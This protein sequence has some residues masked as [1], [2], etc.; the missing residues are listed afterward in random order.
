MIEAKQLS[1]DILLH[2]SQTLDIPLGSLIATISLLDE[3]GTVPF[4]AR[5][6]KEATGALDEV[7]IRDFEEK[8]SYFRELLSRRETILASISEQGKLTDD[9]RQKIEATLHRGELEDLYLPY[10]RPSGNSST[11]KASSS[12]AS[13]WMQSTRRTSSRCTTTIVSQ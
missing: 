12:V 1:P 8:L 10:A 5:Y 2:I 6:R 9:L 7:K 4:I 13:P 11:M 3:G